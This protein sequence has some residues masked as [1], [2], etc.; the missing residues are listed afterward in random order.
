MALRLAQ[1]TD[2][3]NDNTNDLYETSHR[4]DSG[5][6]TSNALRLNKP[7]VASIPLFPKSHTGSLNRPSSVYIV[8]EELFGMF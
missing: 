1:N 2:D 3:S 6:C 8:Q 5:L 4:T 7:Q